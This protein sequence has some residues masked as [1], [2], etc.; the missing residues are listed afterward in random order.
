MSTHFGEALLLAYVR[1]I[2]EEDI[3]EELLL[4]RT[5]ETDAK[6][7]SIFNVL[8]NFFTEKSIQFTNII[9]IATD[10]APAMVGRYRGLISHLKR[11]VPGL[12]AIHCVIHRQHLV[13]KHLSDRLKQSFYFGIKAVNEIRS[14]ASN[15]RLFAQWCDENDEDFQ[16][17][18]L[19]TEAR[20]L[21]KGAC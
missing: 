2:V 14:N 13:T 8:S 4:T 11:T 1:F 18:L 12:T 3:H 7:E 15:T 20:W 5:L 10:G 9:S 17:L 19:H 21:S 6:G 16:R